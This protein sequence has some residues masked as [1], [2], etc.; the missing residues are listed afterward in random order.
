[1]ADKSVIA[2]VSGL[3][4]VDKKI[5]TKEYVSP[6]LL[7]LR[8][9]ART[10]SM[11]Q[12][13]ESAALKPKPTTTKVSDNNDFVMIDRGGLPR[14]HQP[15]TFDKQ[16][17]TAAKLVKKTGN[18]LE[19]N[20]VDVVE[21]RATFDSTNRVDDDLLALGLD[22]AK[23]T[24][25]YAFAMLGKEKLQEERK[26]LVE[27]LA[28]MKAE[29]QHLKDMLSALHCQEDRKSGMLSYR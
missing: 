19:W 25:A 20:L 13:K 7:A 4:L 22:F 8:E 29:N 18:D 12:V 11:T 27:E 10:K 1:M 9:R 6:A 14:V 16:E 23:M 3:K 2:G 26:G 21:E 24:E 17:K 5:T 15:S 28:A